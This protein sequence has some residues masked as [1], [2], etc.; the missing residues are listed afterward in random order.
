MQ[1]KPDDLAQTHELID[2]SSLSLFIHAPY[3]INLCAKSQPCLQK[4]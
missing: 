2:Q 1:L 4:I 3:V